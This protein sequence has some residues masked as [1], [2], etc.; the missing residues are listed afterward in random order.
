MQHIRLSVLALA[1]V[2]SPV[3]MGAEIKVISAEAVR[4]ALE[5]VAAQYTKDSGNTVSFAFMTA[6]QVR[7]TVQAGEAADIAIA[8]NTVIG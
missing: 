3:A 7:D 1:I 5:S 4:D 6:G 8:S 2:A